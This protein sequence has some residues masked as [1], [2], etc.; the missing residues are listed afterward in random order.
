MRGQEWQGGRAP[1]GHPF[2]KTEQGW[3]VAAPPVLAL[4]VGAQGWRVM[5]AHGTARA[6][7]GV[8]SS[9]PP[10][11]CSRLSRAGQV[12]SGSGQV[13]LI[14][15][16]EEEDAEGGKG[17]FPA[18]VLAWGCTSWEPGGRLGRSLE[19]ARQ[20]LK[21]P[22]RPSTM[23]CVLGTAWLGPTLEIKARATSA[24]GDTGASPQRELGFPGGATVRGSLQCHG[25]LWHGADPGRVLSPLDV[26]LD[27]LRKPFWSSREAPGWPWQPLMLVSA[28]G[29]LTAPSP[30][31]LCLSGQDYGLSRPP[32]QFGSI[33][34]VRGNG[35]P[36]PL[37]RS[38]ACSARV[39]PGCPSA[40]LGRFPQ[41]SASS[42]PIT[43]GG[44]V[45]V[46]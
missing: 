6:A 15:P 37:G 43:R 46:S 11:G 7:A 39:G 28:G 1:V 44:T 33:Y 8:C 4:C 42:C 19:D 9:P 38:R 26:P 40:E 5:G 27:G 30:C 24:G 12:L 17:S 31:P 16:G 14:A 21:G 20:N 34:H 22:W 25:R 45:L 35:T 10:Q 32:P 13:L 41:P 23:P 18:I 2:H 36:Q 29:T 3:E